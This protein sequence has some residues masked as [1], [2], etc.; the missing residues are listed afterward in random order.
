MFLR[1]DKKKKVIKET[2]VIFHFYLSENT[3]KEYIKTSHEAG[4]LFSTHAT[5]K[6]TVYSIL[7]RGC[8]FFYNLIRKKSQFKTLVEEKAAEQDFLR[9]IPHVQEAYVKNAQYHQKL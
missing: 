5:D 3:I 2:P 9:G 6:G 1:Q 8:F 7:Q 4:E